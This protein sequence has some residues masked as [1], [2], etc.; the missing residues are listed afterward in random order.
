MMNK[1]KITTEQYN[2]V[3]DAIRDGIQA[4]RHHKKATSRVVDA[5]KD[6]LARVLPGHH[7]CVMLNGEYGVAEKLHIWTAVDLIHY[8]DRIVVYGRGNMDAAT[9]KISWADGLLNGLGVNDTRDYQEREGAE[10][11]L[12]PSFEK[13]EAEIAELEKRIQQ[14]Q[15]AALAKIV[16]LP[17]PDAAAIRKE[18]Y[19][20]NRPSK[21]AQARFPLLF[22]SK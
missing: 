7:F 1:S 22:P 15:E 2:Q 6:Q 9:D 20:W 10:V 8:D 11:P 19:F 21:K 13:Q 5:I 4:T 16:A 3:I 14:I 18:P 17:I 12:Y